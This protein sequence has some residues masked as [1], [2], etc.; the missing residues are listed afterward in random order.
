[1]TADI[2]TD[3]PATMAAPG[4]HYSHAVAGGGLVFVSGQFWIATG[5][6]RRDTT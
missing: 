3:N 2:R 1:M 6:V 4:G 5:Y